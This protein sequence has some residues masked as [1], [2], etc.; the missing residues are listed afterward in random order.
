MKALHILSL[1]FVVLMVAGCSHSHQLEKLDKQQSALAV[2]IEEPSNPEWDTLVL[3]REGEV[4]EPRTVKLQ[5]NERAK[6]APGTIV[7][8]TNNHVLIFVQSERKLILYPVA[9]GR[10]G[11]SW[12]GEGQIIAKRQWP[13]WHPP[14]E[15]REREALKNNFLPE[16]MEGGLDNPLGARALYISG[17]QYRIHGTNHPETIGTDASSGCFRMYASHAIDL[18][19]R[20]PMGARVV[21]L[22]RETEL[23]EQ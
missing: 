4:L 23:A 21:V 18:Y 8:D 20:V 5:E 2:S 17:G 13:S 10:E 15:M 22:D 3:E 11:M 12:S 7:I 6:Y 1:F 14:Q 9:V 16:K 19:N